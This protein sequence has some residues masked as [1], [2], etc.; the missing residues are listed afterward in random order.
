MYAE[1]QVKHASVFWVEENMVNLR[2]VRSKIKE[3]KIGLNIAKDL[4]MIAFLRELYRAFRSS[5]MSFHSMDETK[6]STHEY[7][8]TIIAIE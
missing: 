7:G 1:M 6:V 2:I 3:V 5:D 8:F 4:R